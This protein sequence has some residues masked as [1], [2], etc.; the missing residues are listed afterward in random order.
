MYTAKTAIRSIH[1]KSGNMKSI[2]QQI[3][4]RLLQTQEQETKRV[5]RW[6]RT[7]LRD[8][9][10]G[11]DWTASFV[12]GL[13]WKYRWLIVIAVV[14]NIGAGLA[15]ATTLA[16]FTLALNQLT[17]LVSNTPV[18]ASGTLNT[19]VLQIAQFMG[20]REPVL[21]LILLAV[22]FQLL[23]SGLDYSGQAASAYV[24]VWLESDIQR[25][26]F[27]QM[28]GLR[29]RQIVGSRLGDLAAY[30]SQVAEIGA[31]VQSVNQTFNDLA[32]IIAYTAVLFWI[33]WQFTLVAVIIL[34]LFS[35]AMNRLR[36]GI[37]RSITTYVQTTVRL[38]ERVL[39]YLQGIRLIH[40]FVREDLVIHE[41][42]RLINSGIVPR[43][44]ALLRRAIIGPLFQSVAIIGI[45]AVIG[46]GY[47][48]VTTSQWLNIGGL[49]AYIFVV[50]RTMP[51]ISAMNGQLGMIAGQWPY[52]IRIAELL[53]P[54][55]KER[56]YVPG[57]PL[58]KLDKG[59]EFRAVDLRYPEGERNALQ[60]I[61]FDVP[62]GKMVALVG[63]SGSGK[64]SIINLM[65]GLYQ[66]TGGKILVDGRDLQS[67]DLAA[68]RRLI[69]VVDQDTLIFS[70]SLAANIRFGK[71]DAT[72]AEVQAAAQ[73]ANADD[74]IQEMPKG[75]D[76]EVGD[77]GY[78]LSG[79]Q[80]QR[81][82]IARAVIHDPALL[83]FDEAT[84]ALDSQSE[85]LIQESLEELRKERTVVLIAHRLSTIAKAD[86]IILLENG[87]ILERGTHQELL[88]LRGRYAAMWQLQAAPA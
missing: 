87:Q 66:P 13:L 43:R 10:G 58:E 45:A 60:K 16:V 24:R 63:A 2:Q 39:E 22:F 54:A 55:G 70:T 30:N 50:Y 33:S 41:V 51:R 14:A 42:D 48:I 9:A 86:Q 17:A 76:T 56:E 62:A 15:E 65:L 20:G 52:L 5:P 57:A 1:D 81:I 80:R 72:D 67:Y 29:Y 18:D 6:L 34:G 88:E 61:S 7:L 36:G 46:I 84:S 85:R 23:R 83:F 37:R 79:G 25:R 28:I 8:S 12:R 53:N 21:I 32:I 71:P 31:L 38:N 82:A 47:W 59:I 78:K 75:Y 40:I 19:I 68:W 49:A 44:K 35:L 74:F 26:I 64:S 11:D 3:R 69:G 4:T 73:I 27:A 77:R